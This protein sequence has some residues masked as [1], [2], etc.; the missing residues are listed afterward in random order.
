MSSS[1]TNAAGVAVARAAPHQ[2]ES[3][4]ARIRSPRRGLRLRR[5]PDSAAIL[6][7]LPPGQVVRDPLHVLREAGRLSSAERTGAREHEDA[8]TD[9]G[10]RFLRLGERLHLGLQELA[11]EVLPHPRRVTAREDERVEGRDVDLRPRDRAS[12]GVRL[13]ERGVD[14]LSAR[15]R[16]QA[17]RRARPSGAADRQAGLL[18]APRS[19]TRRRGR[20]RSGASTGRRPP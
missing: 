2:S 11:A 6:P 3:G 4:R 16:R 5:T 15:A 13:L 7:E 19:R 12:E 9:R 8:V 18:P 17:G 1:T 14:T 20:L 10:E